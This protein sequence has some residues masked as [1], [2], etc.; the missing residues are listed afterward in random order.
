MTIGEIIESEFENLE[1]FLATFNFSIQEVQ[2]DVFDMLLKLI[3]K[4]PQK[5]GRLVY[6]DK[7]KQLILKFE[8]QV[9]AEL[10]KGKYYK[11]VQNIIANFDNLEKVRKSVSA[12]LTESERINIFKANIDPIKKGYI[13]KIAQSLGSKDALGLNYTSTIKNLLF[14]HAALGL[15]VSEATERLFKIAMSKEPGG[16][17]LGR[18]AGQVARDSL[19]NFTGS[20]DQAIGDYIGAKDVNYLGNV[21]EDSRPQC[22]RWVVKFKGF[23]PGNKLKSEIN[24]AKKNGKGYSDH[25]PDLTVQTF[26]I[27]RGGHNCRHRV[28][29]T[30]TNPDRAKIEAIEE[31][32]R[33]ESEKFQKQQE[34][35]LTGKTKQLYEAAKKKVDYQIQLYGK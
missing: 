4:L 25:L 33:I 32:Y 3:A 8:D 35:K 5:E 7:V 29:L 23:I 11:G 2:S 34:K 15:T 22:I 30:K 1:S 27:V 21:I 16:G 12:Y 24:W 28:S 13:Q 19:F 6:E 9:I 18:Y 31:R 10:G 17:L 14:E 20:V 26:A